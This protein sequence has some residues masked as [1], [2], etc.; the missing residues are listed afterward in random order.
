M[1]ALAITASQVL[2]AATGVDSKTLLASEAVTA[3]QTLYENASSQW[4]LGDANASVLTA[5]VKGIA[6]HAASPGQPLKA[7]T[8]GD[9]TLGAAAAPVVGTPYV[10]GATPGSIHPVADLVATWY[11]TFLGVG[12]TGNILTMPPTGPFASGQLT[13]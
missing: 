5:A 8:G 2:A 10:A 9:I 12:K 3:G 4:A 6:L 11:T 7:H 13:P 1:V